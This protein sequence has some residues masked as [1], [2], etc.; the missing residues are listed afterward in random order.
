MKPAFQLPFKCG[1]TWRAST[2][3]GHAPDQDSLDLLQFSDGA[4]VSADQEVLASAAGKVIEAHN[5]ESEDPPYGSVITIQHEGEWQSQY[6]H[7][8]DTLAVQKEHF[9]T[10]GQKIATVG[11]KIAIFGTAN[12]HLHYVQLKGAGNA[13][14]CTFNGVDTKV[15]SGAEN[16]DGTYPTEN[17]VSANCPVAPFGPPVS[18]VSRGPN[19][20]DVFAVGQDGRIL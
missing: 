6:V 19:C 8:D 9:V 13:V 4:N 7:L 18:A 3:N 14:R 11:G 17:I 2:Y 15:Y 20:L 10:R 5:T 12:A 1:Q 16:P